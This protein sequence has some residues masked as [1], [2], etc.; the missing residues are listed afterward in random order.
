MTT[1]GPPPF[2]PV[3]G[4]DLWC[5]D[6]VP[7]PALGI[8]VHALRRAWTDGRHGALIAPKGMASDAVIRVGDWTVHLW[9]DGSAAARH[10]THGLLPFP[11][12]LGQRGDA[13]RDAFA[14][15]IATGAEDGLPLH[16]HTVSEA[17]VPYPVPG[18]IRLGQDGKNAGLVPPKGWLHNALDSV[19]EKAQTTPWIKAI[20][21]LH[22]GDCFPTDAA[23]LWWEPTHGIDTQR[24]RWEERVAQAL[25]LAVALAAGEGKAPKEASLR[26]F[27][28]GHALF[29]DRVVR[30]AKIEAHRHSTMGTAVVRHLN[31]LLAED[32]RGFDG[33]HWK[34]A[35]LPGGKGHGRE[36]LRYLPVS[37]PDAIELRALALPTPSA[38]QIV[39]AQAW[40]AAQDA[41]AQA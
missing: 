12:L 24:K 8:A 10:K 9:K 5:L 3:F 41:T 1:F 17:G 19:M 13:R 33:S 32:L 38:H 14:E 15:G 2:A 26:F 18:A 6:L 36:A 11:F 28:K 29:P 39:A 22:N 21:V 7:A 16:L 35:S 20:H 27:V 4:P 31:R 37:A 23:L 30:P 25:P 34:M 40:Y